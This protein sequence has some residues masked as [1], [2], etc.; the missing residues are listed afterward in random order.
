MS[1]ETPRMVSLD[2]LLTHFGRLELNLKLA[3]G[4]KESGFYRSVIV[5][6]L[7]IADAGEPPIEPSEITI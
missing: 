7:R 2:N 5:D 6:I 1:T 3:G 4:F